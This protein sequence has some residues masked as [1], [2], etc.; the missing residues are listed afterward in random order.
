MLQM[1]ACLAG[2]VHGVAENFKRSHWNLMQVKAECFA[3][4]V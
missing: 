3:R 1:G 4:L 2:A